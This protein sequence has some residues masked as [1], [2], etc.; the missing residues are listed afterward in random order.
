MAALISLFVVVLSSLL[1]TRVAT[2]MLTLTGMSRE[3]ARFQARSA[4]TGTG[5]ATAEAEAVVNHPVRR[6]IIMSMMLLGNAGIVSGLATLLLSF[7]SASGS[8]DV[9]RRLLIL[10]AGLTALW[11]LAANQIA[12]RVLSRFIER[13]LRR[14]TDLDVRDYVGLLRLSDEWVV[15]EIEI[16]EGDWLC[17]V[18]LEELSLSAE[19]VIVLGIARAEG[20]WI[21]APHKDTR[22][23]HGDVAVVYGKRATLERVDA[24]ER[25]AEGEMDWVASQIEFT[26]EYLEQ[27]DEDRADE[28]DVDEGPVERQLAV[29]ERMEPPRTEPGNP[30]LIPVEPVDDETGD[31]PRGER[32]SA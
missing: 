20:R 13:A 1:V 8:G 25:T 17:D 10:A 30:A 32:D 3:S 23:H 7:S 4:F 11:A 19:G 18:T 27:R 29:G 16:E 31:E 9:V 5:F 28:P 22:M 6:R 21:G 15:G 14:F 2:V 24:R 26:A 12:D